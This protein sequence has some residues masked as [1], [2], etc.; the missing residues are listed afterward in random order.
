MDYS[1]R[2]QAPYGFRWTGGHM[3]RD[4]V[5]AR[6]RREAFDL[7]L[8]LG[9]LGAV[10]RS[11]NSTGHV[12]R[13]AGKWTDVQVAR[14]LQCPS[15]IGHYETNRSEKDTSGLRRQTL[16]GERVTVECEPIVS[17]ETWDRVSELINKQRARRE[18]SKEEVIPPS[19]LVWCGCG[20]KMKLLDGDKKFA[21]RRCPTQISADDL[22]AIFAEDFAD[23]V[24]A[25][26]ALAAALESS[27]ARREW[28]REM[29]AGESELEATARQRAG[30]ERMFAEKAIS[31]ARFEE[32]YVPQESRVRELEGKL[33]SL[34]E[35]LA[36]Q[37]SPPSV[38]PKADWISLWPSWPASHRRR[39]IATFVSAFTVSG[40][41]VQIAYLLPE[42]S[43]SEETAE[44]QQITG[45]TNQTSP[46]RPGVHS[47]AKAGREMPHHRTEPGEAE[48]ADSP[49]RA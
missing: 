21:C 13:R 25:H 43:G 23:A 20:E 19:G 48:R 8:K 46:R 11:L 38:T 6:T 42:P 3:V 5:E 24:A 33:A 2:G 26:P 22:E 17:R 31:K 30:V 14:I 34:K 32:L 37:A 9:S 29:A 44:P 10:A 49:E 16:I 39:I 35:K 36:T 47:P 41:E 40:E 15:A 1:K 4:D 18:T 7:F 28:M 27:S 12:T 45:P